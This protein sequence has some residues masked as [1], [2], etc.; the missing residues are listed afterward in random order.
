MGGGGDDTDFNA[1]DGNDNDEGE[2]C[3]HGQERSVARNVQPPS[4]R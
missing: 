3:Y 2:I 4:E 1:G